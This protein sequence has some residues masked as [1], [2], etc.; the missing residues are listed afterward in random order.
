MAKRKRRIISF[1]FLM[2]LVTVLLVGFYYYRL[3]FGPVLN[4]KKESVAF[5][6]HTGWSQ[7]NVFDALISMDI[8]K[9]PKAVKWV[10][11]RKNYDGGLVVPGKYTLKNG[12]N[13]NDLVNHL[14]AGNGEEEVKIVLN[15]ARTL[16][17]LAGKASANIEADSI[18]ILDKLT[19]PEVIG[20]YGFSAETFK[21]MFLPDTYYTE[22]DTDADEFLERMA[23]EY[24]KFWTEERIQSAKIQ[25]L[26]QSQVTTLASIVQAEQQTHPEERAAIAGLY[27]NRLNRGMRLQSDPTVVYAVGD[28]NINRVLTKHLSFASPYNTY[29]NSGLPPGPINI[30][31]KQAIDAVLNAE[32]NDYIYMCAKA[33]FSGYHAFAKS[34]TEHIRNARAFQNALN[35]RKIYK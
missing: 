30:P 11:E 3:V 18:S 1:G 22:W 33:D 5:Y 32:D 15:H 7:D 31:T 9:K 29:I 12:I 14:R 26:S 34:H 20:R 10:M 16:Q 24:K 25:G 28:F 35:Q 4:M 19:D 27:L 21:A 8:V 23:S 13:A 17:E 2:F 6:I